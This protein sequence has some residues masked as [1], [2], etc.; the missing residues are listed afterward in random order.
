MVTIGSVVADRY[1][2]NALIDAGGLGS[3]WRAVDRRSGEVVA[4]KTRDYSSGTDEMFGRRYVAEMRYLAAISNPGVVP[5]LGYGHDE[6]IVWSI[7]P[8][9]TGESVRARLARVG[10][11]TPAVAMAWLA[12]AATT[13]CEVHHH[14]VVHRG[15]RPSRLFLLT[16]ERIVLTDFGLVSAPS[17]A[18]ISA[19]PHLA[20]AAYLAPEQAMGEPATRLSDLYQLGLIAYECLAG[21]PPFVAEHPIEVAMMH[22]RQEPPPLP[23]EVPANVR[24][25]VRRCLAKSPAA[26]WPS[27]ATLAQAAT[28][29]T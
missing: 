29:A 10:P 5:V 15:L 16:D 3:V 14:G 22:V 24:T 21:R 12:Q 9:L 2:L 13:M 20:P 11:V 27:A 25:I 17:A 19:A 28:Q 18:N 1:E 26:R 7:M 23:D 4:V 6:P 8:L